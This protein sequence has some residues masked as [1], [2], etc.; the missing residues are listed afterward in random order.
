M[1]DD[2]NSNGTIVFLLMMI[3]GVLLYGK[4][5]MLA[6]IGT[7]FWVALALAVLGIVLWIAWAILTGVF[8]VVSGVFSGVVE[9]GRVLSRATWGGKAIFSARNVKIVLGLALVSLTSF[10]VVLHVIAPY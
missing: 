3:L 10:V 9:G 2:E 4:E 8:E 7:F 5:Q 6:S 1:R